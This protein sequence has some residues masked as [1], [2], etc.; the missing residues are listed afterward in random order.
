LPRHLKQ[1]R[2][3]RRA[4]KVPAPLFPSYLFAAVDMASQRWLA[5]DSTIGVKRLVDSYSLVIDQNSHEAIRFAF[6]TALSKIASAFT[7]A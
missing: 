4:E 7:K 1:W 6:S 5:I 3:A 2:H